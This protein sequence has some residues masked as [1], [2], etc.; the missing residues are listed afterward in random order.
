MSVFLAKR[1]YFQKLTKI[2]LKIDE[3]MFLLGT[4]APQVMHCRKDS[5]MADISSI[6]F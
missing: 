6:Y 5:A 1:E 4:S 2:E 3:I